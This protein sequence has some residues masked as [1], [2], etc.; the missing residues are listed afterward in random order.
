MTK[1]KPQPVT[2]MAYVAR[3]SCGGLVMATTYHHPRD[4]A[5]SVAECIRDGY[6][7]ETMTIEDVRQIDWCKTHGQCK[8]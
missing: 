5:T 7:I 1:G 4:A 8:D 3:C 2:P 6:S